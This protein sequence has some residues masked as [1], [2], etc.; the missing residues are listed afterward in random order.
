MADAADGAITDS[1]F[2]EFIKG[3]APNML[4]FAGGGLQGTI[5]Q[6]KT[7]WTRRF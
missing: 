3:F 1:E 5:E 2:A 7:V 4:N 6:K